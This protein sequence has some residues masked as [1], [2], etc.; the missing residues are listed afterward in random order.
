M[1]YHIKELQINSPKRFYV[2]TTSTGRHHSETPL[3]LAVARRQ[4]AALHMYAED[5]KK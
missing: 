2:V 4:L 5:K 3:T 1:P